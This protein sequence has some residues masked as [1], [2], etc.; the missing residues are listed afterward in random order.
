[1]GLGSIRAA[2]RQLQD[3]R[4]VKSVTGVPWAIARGN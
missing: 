2:K 3:F 1:M 4:Q